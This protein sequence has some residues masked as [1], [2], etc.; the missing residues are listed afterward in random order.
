M[1]SKQNRSKL[2]K[3]EQTLKN[4]FSLRRKNMTPDSNFLSPKMYLKNLSRESWLL[5]PE[6]IFR[7]IFIG[8]F[9]GIASLAV[10]LLL[11]ELLTGVYN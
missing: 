6:T 10:L 7:F 1:L 4:D 5:R 9:S 2:K 8:C 3:T 11:F